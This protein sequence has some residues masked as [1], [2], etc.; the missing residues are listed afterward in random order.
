MEIK[1]IN[2]DMRYSV[3]I[4]VLIGLLIGLMLMLSGCSTVHVT[5]TQDGVLEVSYRTLLTKIVA[6]ELQVERTSG[7]AYKVGFNAESIDRGSEIAAMRDILELFTTGRVRE[8]D[9]D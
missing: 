9:N 7:E 4:G 8:E 2:R 6:P 1:M 3:Y 5:R